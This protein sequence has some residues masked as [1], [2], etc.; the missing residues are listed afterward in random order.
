MWQNLFSNKRLFYSLLLSFLLSFIFLKEIKAKDYGICGNTFEIQEENLL[1]YIND[2]LK[3][4]DLKEWQRDFVEVSKDSIQRPK[5]TIL[6]Y[7]KNKRVYYF[8]PSIDNQ[9]R[10]ACIEATDN[11][12][13]IFAKKGDRINPLDKINLTKKLIFIDGDSREQIDYAINL[14]NASNGRAKIILIK[15]SIVDLINKL[16][17]KIYFDQNGILV[18]KFSIKHIPAIISQENKLLKIEEVVLSY[19][20]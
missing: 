7:A 15:G 8:D 14:Y 17:I 9:E 4:I 10:K 19:D 12:G 6:P 13:V 1:E 2:K 3:A 11:R 20:D 16:N 18:N 5:A